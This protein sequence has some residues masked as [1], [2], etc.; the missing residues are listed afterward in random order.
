MASATA[1]FD[2]TLARL[3]SVLDGQVRR[4]EALEARIDAE[5][6]EARRQRMRDASE[7][8]REIAARYDDSFRSF[9]VTVPEAADD[10]PPS[11]YR[12]R[13]FNRLARRLASDHELSSIRADDLGSQPVVFDN[14]EAMLL[15]AARAEG[16]RP[17]IENLPSDGSMVMRTRTDDMNQR[18][19]E[20]F[21]R[22]SFIKSLGRPGRPVERIVD[23]RSN[24][25]IWG[26]PLSQ[27]R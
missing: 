8:R 3:D 9:G 27:A 14:F 15:Q 1:R 17:S 4:V 25:V 7:Q 16:S 5:R 23:R 19:T 22:E 24:S 6:E 21:G 13:L 18:M 2:E 12:A 26:K 20:W 11:R 10:E